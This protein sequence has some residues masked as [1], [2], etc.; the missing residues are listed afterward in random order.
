[1]KDNRCK[2]CVYNGTLCDPS[3]WKKKEI[4]KCWHSTP[5]MSNRN[6]GERRLRQRREL[7]STQ[8]VKRIN[9]RTSRIEIEN[10][11]AFRRAQK[12]A[13]EKREL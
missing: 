13:K 12:L 6:A 3:T 8:R 10:G 11:E 1:M 5:V 4:A 9:R 7:E 2:Y